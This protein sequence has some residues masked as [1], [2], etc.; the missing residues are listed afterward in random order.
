MPTVILLEPSMKTVFSTVDARP[1]VFCQFMNTIFP[2]ASTYD[3]N[4][5]KAQTGSILKRE[6]SQALMS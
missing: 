5:P 3:P 2:L 4:V 6:T 1:I